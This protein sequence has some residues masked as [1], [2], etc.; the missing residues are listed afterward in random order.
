M[1]F[2][3]L[4]EVVIASYSSGSWHPLLKILNKMLKILVCFIFFFNYSIVR[5]MD[6]MGVRMDEDSVVKNILS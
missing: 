2:D 5:T 1:I 3:R 4:E 6:L